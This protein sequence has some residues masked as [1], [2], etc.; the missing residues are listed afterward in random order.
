MINVKTSND[1]RA[2][3][4][5]GFWALKFIVLIGLILGSFYIPAD[6]DS[7][8][9]HV[10]FDNFLMYLGSIGGALVRIFW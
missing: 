9:Q 1:F 4:Q 2:K 5:N 6:R 10:D 8:H 3:I 7:K